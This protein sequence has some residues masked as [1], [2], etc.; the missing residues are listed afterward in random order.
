ME[1]VISLIFHGC[2]LVKDLE[3]NLPNLANQ[4]S[5]LIKSC[6]EIVRVFGDT[7]E[8]LSALEVAAYGQMMH[9][10]LLEQMEIGGGGGVVQEWLRF[11]QA[12]DMVV[13]HTSSQVHHGLPESSRV[14]G[15]DRGE[16]GLE[17]I[18]VRE[19]GGGD[20]AVQPMDAVDSAG[21]SGVQRPRRRNEADRRT[22]R[23]PAPRMGNTEVPPEDGYTW[24][25]Y[26]QKEILGSRFPRAYYRC[27]HQKMYQ[28][29]AKKQVQRLDH[30]PYIFE[31]TYR[32][33]HT[34]TMSTT[35]PS[36][37]PPP[38]E[39]ITTQSPPVPLPTSVPLSHWLS[40][41]IRPSGEGTSGNTTTTTTTTTFDHVQMYR[42]DQFGL[43]SG[44]GPSGTTGGSGGA[45]PRS[46]SMGGSGGG[47]P[48]TVQYV[49][50][51]RQ[52]LADLAD[53]MF[54]SGSSSN[55]SIELIFSGMED[56]WEGGDHNK[57]N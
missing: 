24:R 54:N 40:M 11:S 26:G 56:K 35:A 3:M 10:D 16:V 32:G 44:A 43:G 30:D 4:P 37:L 21:G 31:V 47:P 29:P 50:Y 34:C 53:V 55:N 36:I 15:M 5:S 42:D 49:D 23:V 13:L 27:T 52:G 9:R 46:N 33:D 48:S 17:A 7:R 19:L 18:N 20:L 25:K 57:K 38:N 1:E 22:V 51:H 2:K 28:C 45:G 39:P 14:G 41:D 6:D 12:M 8:R